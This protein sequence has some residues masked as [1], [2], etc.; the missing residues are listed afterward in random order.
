MK[1]L[2]LAS[3]AA[4][5]ILAA[6]SASAAGYAL[7]CGKT[8]DSASARLLGAKTIVVEDKRIREIRDGKVD[9]DGLPSV[10]LSGHTCSPGCFPAS[11]NSLWETMMNLRERQR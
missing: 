2:P 8:F 7:Q 3:A 1:A 10:D 4:L 11:T 9:I 6:D 5:F